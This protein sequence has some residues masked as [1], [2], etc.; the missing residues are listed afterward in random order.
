MDTYCCQALEENDI[1]GL[2]DALTAGLNKLRIHMEK[3]LVSD[4]PLL[5]AGECVFTVSEVYYIHIDV[6]TSST[7][8]NASLIFR[9]RDLVVTHQ[10]RSSCVSSS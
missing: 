4:Y 8:E 7:S 9:R 6:S 1:H 10:S 5:G 2:E 3:A